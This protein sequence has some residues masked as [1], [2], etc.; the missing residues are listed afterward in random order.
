MIVVGG[1]VTFWEISVD[2]EFN[3]NWKASRAGVVVVAPS[4]LSS[5]NNTIVNSM[6]RLEHLCCEYA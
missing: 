1:L 2:R 3:E 4:T 5:H 6:W